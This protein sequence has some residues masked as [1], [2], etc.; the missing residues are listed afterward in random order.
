METSDRFQSAIEL[1]DGIHTRDP[2]VETVDGQSLPAAVLYARRM[3]QWLRK[4]EPNASE[5]LRLAAYS[6]HL[7][8][9]EIPRSTYP[10]DRA[11]Y[12]RWRTALAS[13]HADEAGRVLQK[14]GY[15]DATISRV[16]ALLRKERLK[17]NPEAQLLEDVACLVFLEFHFV[18]FSQRHDEQKLIGILQR[19]WKKMSTRGHAEALK[20]ELPP[21]KRRLL[22]NALGGDSPGE[23]NTFPPSPAG[24]GPG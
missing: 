8:R 19:T 2:N 16:Q 20:L 11:G 12:H 24:R 22:E 4:L 15:D 5:A 9:W 23:A 17:A 10:M 18:D 21:Q 7:K 3:T 1:F 13:F 14:A 6:Q